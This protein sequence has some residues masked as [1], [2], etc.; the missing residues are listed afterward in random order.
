MKFFVR[1]IHP[2]TSCAYLA[3]FREPNEIE[4]DTGFENG[5]CVARITPGHD[6]R[7]SQLRYA[8][9]V[10]YALSQI[11]DFKNN[12]RSDAR[13]YAATL[14]LNM[15][16]TYIERLAYQIDEVDAHV[17]DLYCAM[18]E[19]IESICVTIQGTMQPKHSISPEDW[20]KWA[21]N[22]LVIHSTSP[23]RRNI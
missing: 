21:E 4:L 17:K 20:M 23:F 1:E 7:D 11:Y 14:P 19:V 6:P 22:M 8:E 2:G 3:I 15:E 12:L 18:K 10:A 9:A 5:V 13:D 16:R